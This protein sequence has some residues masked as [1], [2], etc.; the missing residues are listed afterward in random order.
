MCRIAHRQWAMSASCALRCV[1]I[2]GCGMSVD[3][4]SGGGMVPRC[5]RTWQSNRQPT[6]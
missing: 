6:I 3:E 5:R 2:T 1:A 4:L